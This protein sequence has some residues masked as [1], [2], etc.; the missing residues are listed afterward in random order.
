M[1]TEAKSIVDLKKGRIQGPVA[2]M[3]VDLALSTGLRVSEMADLKIQ[4]IDFKRGSLKVVRLKRKKK[5]KETMAIGKDLMDH[6]REYLEWD[7]R[8]KGS[9]FV[10]QRGPITYR[11]LQQ[12]WKAAIKRACLPEELSIH[13]AR[14]TLATHLLK[15]TGNLRQVQKQ[16]GHASPATT[17]NMYADIAFEDMQDCVNGVYD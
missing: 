5:T 9:L 1:V 2:W 7:D 16:L 3:L 11:G 12:M 17:A 10:G 8:T 14:H 6:L 4:D 13:S 15:K